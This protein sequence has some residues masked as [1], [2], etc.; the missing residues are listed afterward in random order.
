[1]LTDES[2]EQLWS[3]SNP[4]ADV[5]PNMWCNAAVSTM[6]V[7]GIVQGYPDGSFRP[8]ANITRAEFA[9]SLIHIWVPT[10]MAAI[11]S[12]SLSMAALLRPRKAQP[13]SLIR[14]LFLPPLTPG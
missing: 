9:L 1:M 11:W 7:G 2:R 8:R 4:Y 12:S 14:S 10:P 5:A 3:Q 6:T 13:P